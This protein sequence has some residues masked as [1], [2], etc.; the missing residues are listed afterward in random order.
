MFTIETPK[1]ERNRRGDKLRDCLL[2][3]V[4]RSQNKNRLWEAFMIALRDVRYED[5]EDADE[6]EEE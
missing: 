4:W 2:E 5:E 1:P 6:E 3:E